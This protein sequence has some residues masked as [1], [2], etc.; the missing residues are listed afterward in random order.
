MVT[1]KNQMKV[2]CKII[3]YSWSHVE[4]LISWSQLWDMQ[5][6]PIHHQK[7]HDYFFSLLLEGICMTTEVDV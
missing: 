4:A 1:V 7:C 3:Y 6:E 5:Q 2:L